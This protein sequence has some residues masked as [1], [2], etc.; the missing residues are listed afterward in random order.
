MLGDALECCDSA[1][2]FAG[3]RRNG[4]AV[5]AVDLE[6]ISWAR[7]AVLH[8]AR[9][10]NSCRLLMTENPNGSEWHH[11]HL[12]PRHSSSQKIMSLD[13][14][15]AGPAQPRGDAKANN[16]LPGNGGRPGEPGYG[17]KSGSV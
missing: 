5:G 14:R 7:W 16:W 9:V 3:G 8:I 17:S 1:R 13:R 10:I 4:G 2:V 6:V 12:Q 15:C 11:R